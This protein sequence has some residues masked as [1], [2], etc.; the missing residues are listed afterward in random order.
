MRASGIWQHRDDYI[1]NAF[2]GINDALGGYDERAGRVQVLWKPTDDFNVLFNIHGRSLDGTAAVFRA[3]ILGPGN[4]HLNSNYIP[5][6]VSSTRASSIEER[7]PA[8]I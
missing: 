3:N 2:L 4:D 7:E 6:T 8:E 5:D 1:S